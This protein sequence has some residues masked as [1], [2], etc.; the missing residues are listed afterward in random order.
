M[1]NSNDNPLESLSVSKVFRGAKK[2][3]M[4]NAYCIDNKII[5]EYNEFN[6]SLRLTT[7]NR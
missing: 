7:A 4:D 5:R 3:M 2:D 6:E 1:T